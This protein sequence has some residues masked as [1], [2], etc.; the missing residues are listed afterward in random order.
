MSDS[1]FGKLFSLFTAD[2]KGCE[3]YCD[4]CGAHMNIQPGFTTAD[5]SWECTECGCLNDVSEDNIREEDDDYEI[6]DEY[7]DDDDEE[8]YCNVCERSDEYPRCTLTC[9]YDDD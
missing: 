6:Y 2:D 1:L 9:P 4:E 5:D 8:S 7:D 3:W